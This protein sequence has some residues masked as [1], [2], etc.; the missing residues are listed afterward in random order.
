[1]SET[2]DQAGAPPAPATLLPVREALG[3]A[4]YLRQYP[5]RS[6]ET[7][8]DRKNLCVVVLAD[9]VERLRVELSGL[10][11]QAGIRDEMLRRAE[12]AVRELGIGD[13]LQE[14]RAELGIR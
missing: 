12:S 11:A 13:T 8:D 10:H 9:E 4:R 3:L 2:N 14:I 5:P 6:A 1:M 7:I